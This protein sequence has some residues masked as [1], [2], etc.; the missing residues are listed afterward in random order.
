MPTVTLEIEE[1]VFREAEQLA[2]RRNT[3][4]GRLVLGALT[5][6]IG[7]EERWR[8]AMERFNRA[9]REHPIEVGERTWTR[10][11]LYER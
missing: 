7:Q 3:T 10:E 2:Q 4:V 8:T 11:D 6:L 5:E 9:I 1:A